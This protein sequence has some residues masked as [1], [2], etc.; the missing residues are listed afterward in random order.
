MSMRDVVMTGGEAGRGAEGVEG[1]EQALPQTLDGGRGVDADGSSAEGS[2]GTGSVRS[3]EWAATA[4]RSD[5][6]VAQRR[7]ARAVRQ[8]AKRQRAA[9]GG[10]V[11]PGAAPTAVEDELMA[12][13]DEA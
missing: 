6:G 9:H 11:D 1:R 2:A 4:Q 3:R 13:E 5:D 7:Q 12:G 8:R 10:A